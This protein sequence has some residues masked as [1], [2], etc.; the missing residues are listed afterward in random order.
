MSVAG[1]R[2]PSIEDEPYGEPGRPFAGEKT[3]LFGAA[4]RNFGQVFVLMAGVWFASNMASGLLPS[5]LGKQTDLS[6]TQITGT[7]VLVQFVHALCFPLIGALTDRIGR[8]TF[9]LANGVTVGVICALAFV[10]LAAGKL[11]GLPLVFLLT[12]V[13]RI[14]G[15]SMFAV[16]PSYICE[17]FPASVRG[18]GFGMGY[19][20]SLLVTA[21]YA[22]YQDWLSHLVPYAY[23]PVVLLVVGGVLIVVGA[24][25]GPEIKD[26]DLE[27]VAAEARVRV[28]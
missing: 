4:R 11:S 6:P 3:V 2:W 17:R 14:S 22:Y 18:S 23:T 25:L 1:I 20:L 28:A 19:N 21:G 7:L 12:L 8:R 9:F 26:V 5:L 15:A 24:A 13:I 27:T 10:L 16:T